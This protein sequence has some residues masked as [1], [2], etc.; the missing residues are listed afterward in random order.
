MENYETVSTCIKIL[1]AAIVHHKPT[2][3]SLNF[4]KQGSCNPELIE[5]RIPVSQF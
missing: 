5:V 1:F 4:N 2:E 3:Y